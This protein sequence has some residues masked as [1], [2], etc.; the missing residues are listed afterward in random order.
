MWFNRFI[1]EVV[2]VS[3]KEGEKCMGVTNAPMG[4]SL[5]AQGCYGTEWIPFGGTSSLRFMEKGTF[6]YTVETKITKAKATGRI[7]VE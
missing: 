2:K 6:E 1:N 3:F 5:N 7:V 4:F